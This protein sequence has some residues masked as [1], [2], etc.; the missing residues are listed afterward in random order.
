MVRKTGFLDNR[1]TVQIRADAVT[2]VTIDLT[3][4]APTGEPVVKPPDTGGGSPLKWVLLGGAGAAIAGVL[5]GKGGGG[6]GGGGTATTTVGSTTTTTVPGGSSTTTS[7]GATRFT[8]TGRVTDGNGGAAIQG[9]EPTILD[10]PNAGSYPV[11]SSNGNYSI[12]NLQPGS[13]RHRVPRAELRPEPGPDRDDYERRRSPQPH[14]VALIPAGG[15]QPGDVFSQRH[16]HYYGSGL[17]GRR[18]TIAGQ[19]RRSTPGP[20]KAGAAAT[21][22]IRCRWAAGAVPSATTRF[23]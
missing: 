20:I 9:A 12:P 7:V 1:S 11:T 21:N 14:D 18:R 17:R 13:F 6:G 5:A 8:L 4:N 23:R 19:N 10:G 16:G 3:G 22:G 2:T 15:F